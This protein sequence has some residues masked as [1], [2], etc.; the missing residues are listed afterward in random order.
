MFGDPIRRALESQCASLEQAGIPCTVIEPEDA[1]RLTK[2]VG[3]LPGKD[4][5]IAWQQIAEGKCVAWSTQEERDTLTARI[6][7]ECTMEATI[8]LIYNAYEGG[9]LIASSQIVTAL[10]HLGDP[11]SECWLL[12]AEGPQWIIEDSVYDRTI[13]YLPPHA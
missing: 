4:E 13:C 3:T 10:R 2:W 6:V 11:K 12:S 1:R 9:L 7:A 8:A 5:R